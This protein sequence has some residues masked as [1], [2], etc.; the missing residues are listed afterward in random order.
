MYMKKFSLCQ[1]LVVGTVLL[2]SCQ[3][4][5]ARFYFSSGPASVAVQS[6]VASTPAMPAKPLPSVTPELQTQPSRLSNKSVARI[7]KRMAVIAKAAAIPLVST[8]RLVT[9]PN[10]LQYAS[11]RR[12]APKEGGVKA[13]EAIMR[14]LSIVAIVLGIG[15]I[16]AGISLS[17]VGIGGI[18]IGAILFIAGLIVQIDLSKY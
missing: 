8:R 18:I 3:S 4:E 5:K 15:L 14:V 6:V 16:M 10:H 13:L 7:P 11:N 12:Y 1:G 17:S 9:H 2:G